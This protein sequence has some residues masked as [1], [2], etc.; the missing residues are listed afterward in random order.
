VTVS[1]ITQRSQVQILPPLHSKTAGQSRVRWVTTGPVLAFGV[2]RTSA[3]IASRSASKRLEREE[4]RRRAKVYG[5]PNLGDLLAIDPEVTPGISAHASAVCGRE[6]LETEWILEQMADVLSEDERPGSRRTGRH[7]RVGRVAEGVLFGCAERIED[8]AAD[9]L[10]VSGG[11]L[12]EVGI[13]DLGEDRVGDGPSVGSGSRRTSPRFSKRL[14]RWE[15]RE[16][17][18]LASTASRLIRIVC[19]GWSERL[20]ST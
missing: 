16:S 20:A 7:A 17:S 6:H 10:D 11:R 4:R 14:I 15:S 1:L 2:S 3:D 9:F 8:E 13:P 18:E 5:R 19:S 12:D